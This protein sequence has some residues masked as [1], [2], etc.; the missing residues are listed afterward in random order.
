MV[1]IN[2]YLQEN[3]KEYLTLLKSLVGIKTVYDDKVGIKKALDF[4]KQVLEKSLINYHV[5]FDKEGNLICINKNINSQNDIVYLSS[6]IDTVSVSGQHWDKK[7]KPFTTYEDEES[8]V[9]RGVNDDKAGVAYQ[10]FL[11]KFLATNFPNTS[12]IVF[13]IT[14]QEEQGGMTASEIGR[15][16]G[17]H[18][19]M[20]PKN[21][22]LTLENNIKMTDPITLNI[23]YGEQSAFGIE[24]VDIFPNIK[25]FLI[26]NMDPWNPTSATPEND[27]R[28][29]KWNKLEQTGGHAAT[30]KRE[31]NL[32]Y[33][34]I[35]EN[36]VNELVLKAGTDK[37]ISN[38]PDTIYQAT[39]NSSIPHRVIF[40][41]R[42]ND[43]TD[44]VV[45]ALNNC[46]IC[47]RFIKKL[48]HGYN[49]KNRL[50]KDKIYKK[51]LSVKPKE[52]KINFER[53][54]GSTDS[55]TIYRYCDS[56]LKHKFLP[57]TMGPGCGSQRNAVPPR[58]SHGVNETYMKKPGL[59]AIKYIT[60]LLNKMSL[61][62]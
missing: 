6:H 21:Y 10:L 15:Q 38:I 35:V 25:R 46:K 23:N 41:L 58:L 30:C 44:S 57:I 19:P 7:F 42:T 24:V 27:I 39:T 54:L 5:Y 56:S 8:V 13:T 29:L 50:L 1:N 59:E 43:K 16:L 14:R 20:R 12:N 31:K 32:L 22:L 36:N 28:N 48:D 26:Q 3:Y 4:C 52:L 33:Q 53:N 9:G 17:K 40:D 45:R 62:Q 61:F 49:V 34:L 2:S 47:Y 51:M 60:Q 37:A 18:L 11:A 55:G